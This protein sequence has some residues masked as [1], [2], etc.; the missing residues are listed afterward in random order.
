MPKNELAHLNIAELK[1]QLAARQA[2][3]AKLRFDLADRKLK[4]TSDIPKVRRTIARIQTALQ[5][6][7]LRT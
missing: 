3:L 1:A 5:N 2:E 7:E 6:L 4:R